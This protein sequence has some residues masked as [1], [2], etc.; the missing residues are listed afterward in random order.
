LNERQRAFVRA[1]VDR[2]TA[3]GAEWARAAGYS[4]VADA[5]K[6]R[7]H[8]LWHN[9]RILAAITEETAKRV[10][11]G[12]LIGIAGLIKMASDPRDPNHYRACEALADRGGFS[13]RT[14][15]KVTVEHID[16]G[17]MA[18]IAERMAKEFGLDRLKLIGTNVI[19]EK[20]VERAEASDS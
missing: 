10:K 9:D 17:R 5:A 8:Y 19:E 12:G 2:P 1:C 3:S 4:D 15:H 14:E 18:E 13:A 11:F 16:H 20:V 7:A 6:V